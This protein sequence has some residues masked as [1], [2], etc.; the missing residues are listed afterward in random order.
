MYNYNDL[1]QSALKKYFRRMNS[2][3]QDAVFTVNGAVLVLAGAGSGKTT[4]IVNRIANMVTFGNAYYNDDTEHIC[5]EKDMLFLQN[6][7]NDNTDDIETL[8]N[9]I[10]VNPVKPWNILAI[11]F[12][13]KAANELKSRL[14]AMLG[15]EIGNDI[16]AATFHSA[17]LKI[18]RREIEKIGYSNN[19]TIYDS[20]DSQRVIK[21]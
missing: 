1:K 6:Y 4:V 11:T 9:I 21:S 17:C 16:C 18:L 8:K 15:D 13:N 5:S 14:S 7:I 10:A 3:Q 20:D 2:C 19:F 12:T